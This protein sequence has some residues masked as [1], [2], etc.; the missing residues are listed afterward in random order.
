MLIGK[1]MTQ[2][3][4][5]KSMEHPLGLS[6]S[7]VENLEHE[8]E[9]YPYFEAGW[10]LALKGMNDLGVTNFD[11]ALRRGAVSIA[12]RDVLFSLIRTESEVAV[13]PEKPVEDKS[14]DS[15]GS[16]VKEAESGPVSWKDVNYE[17]DIVMGTSRS[18]GVSSYNINDISVSVSESDN[19]GF[20]DWLDYMEKQ[21]TIQAEVKSEASG[22]KT[23]RRK[24]NRSRSLNLIESFL[25]NDNAETIQIRKQ[26]EP[27]VSKEVEV[28]PA[29]SQVDALADVDNGDVLSET[30]AKIYIKQGQFEKAINIF[31]KLGLKYP[32]K[33]SYFASRINELENK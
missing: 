6:A 17:Y 30:L 23:D 9:E 16:Q 10:M 25:N 26:E 28:K 7:V 14:V 22:A 4:F 3:E 32:E 11:A 27:V 29:E 33:S 15:T 1:S 18:V 19:C 2:E 5:Y 24:K 8:L 31:R 20:S 12:N 21:P 13:E